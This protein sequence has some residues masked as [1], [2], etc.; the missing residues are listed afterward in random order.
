M[1]GRVFKGK[2]W[3]HGDF[4]RFWTG[5]TISQF[6]TQVTVLAFPT[7][8]ILVLHATALQ[9]GILGALEFLAFPVLGLFAGVTAD[10]VRRRPILIACDLGRAVALAS[11]PVA[12][13]FGV[14]TIY[15]MYAVALLVGVFTVF[16]DVSY[17]SY[18]PALIERQDLV[19]GNSKLEI[20][21][22]TA[23]VAGPGVAGF[24]IQVAGGAAAIVVDA[25]SYIGSALLIWLVRRPEPQPAP[26]SVEGAPSGIFAELREGLQVVFGNSILR[27]IVGC[28]ATSNLGSNILFAV[29]LIFFY[30]RLHLSPAEVGIV[31]GAGSI[32]G[33]VGAA[34]SAT[35]ARRL[36]VGPTI[37]AG[38][39]L[40]GIAFLG[41]PAA[42]VLPP[43]PILTLGF[44]VATFGTTVYNVTQ[45]SLRQAIAPNRVQGR[46]NATIRT[47]VWGTLPLGSVIGGILGTT[48]GLLPTIYIGGIVGL[49]SFLWV[50]GKPVR[51]L[52]QQPE[53]VEPTPTIPDASAGLG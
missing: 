14:L 50:L 41:L 22:S 19:E 21:R 9:V 42:L 7:V 48:V 1:L 49:M 47:V 27:R 23:Q 16:F 31:F 32:G 44:A 39:L 12:A 10:R 24:L 15:Q 52:R 53:P 51:S 6:G 46:M 37:I 43:V 33:V 11:I 3:S 40:F 26:A 13:Y 29:V 45:V 18:L 5:Q 28:T 34:V 35:M 2:L 36:N 30:R 25:V 38:C 17:Q 8:A 4:V 20:S